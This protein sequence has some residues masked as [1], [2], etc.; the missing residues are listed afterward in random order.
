M[1]QP[2]YYGLIM[3]GGRGTRFWPRS[4][5]ADTAARSVT[6]TISMDRTCSRS[7]FCWTAI[8]DITFY[9]E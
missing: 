1:P 2:N 8:D 6:R 9:P 4:R 3:A 7:R 5:A